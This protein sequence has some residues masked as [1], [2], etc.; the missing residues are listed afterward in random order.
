MIIELFGPPGV[1][2]TSFAGALAAQLRERGRHV[3]LVLSYR[4]SEYPL[5]FRADR[6]ARLG[7]PAA[8]RRL[9]RPMVE[10]F[11][12]GH[13]MSSCEAHAMAELMRVLVPKNFIW[14][15]RLRQYLLRLSRNRR[16]AELAA[17]IT[18]FDQGFVQAVYTLAL[19]ARA[20]D[21]ERLRLALDAVPLPDL[22]VRIDASI[23]ILGARLVERRNRQGRVERLFDLD[24][25]TNLGSVWVFD[26]LHELLQARGQRVVCVASADRQSLSDGIGKVEAVTIE[27]HG[28][29]P[30]APAGRRDGV[31]W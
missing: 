8:L 12:A 9:T 18:L 25:A 28:R 22:L 3:D 1:G 24:V 14:S 21:R 2:K 23:E 27:T 17:H 29:V 11:A 26:Q 5:T 30:V 15:L 20:V 31:R 16:A 19:Q 6:A 7:I 13:S 10:S 4:P